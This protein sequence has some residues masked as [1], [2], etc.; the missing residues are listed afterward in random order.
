MTASCRICGRQ[1]KASE[2]GRPLMSTCPCVKTP[3][4]CA[5]CGH[6]KS[7][8][9]TGWDA[10]GCMVGVCTCRCWEEAEEPER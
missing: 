2:D 10:A 5:K 1:C 4:R 9:D 6:P 7:S 8:H 3:N